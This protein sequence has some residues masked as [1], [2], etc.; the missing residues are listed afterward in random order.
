MVADLWAHQYW[1]QPSYNQEMKSKPLTHS[2]G[3]REIYAVVAVYLFVF[4]KNPNLP[5]VVGYDVKIISLM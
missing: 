5:V 4:A 1:P 2:G 3:D